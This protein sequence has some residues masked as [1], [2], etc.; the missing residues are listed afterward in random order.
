MPSTS[1]RG[2]P[3]M[4]SRML[5]DSPLFISTSLLGRNVCPG[6]AAVNQESRGVDVGRLVGGGVGDLGRGGPH[7][8]YKG[9]RVYDRAPAPLQQARYPVLAAEVDGLEVDALDPLPGVHLRLQDRV[10]VRRA[11]AGV[12][13]EDVHAP[14]VLRRLPVHPLHVVRVRN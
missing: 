3:P 10:V 11:Y 12:V 2:V 14:E 5:L 13:E 6:E 8:R 9:R 1:T 7:H 4:A